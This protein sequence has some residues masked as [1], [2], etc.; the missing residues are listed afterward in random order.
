MKRKKLIVVNTYYQLIFALQLL[1]SIYRNDIVDIIISDQSKD[2]YNISKKVLKLKLFNNVYYEKTKEYTKTN[3]SIFKQLKSAKDVF[4]GTRFYEEV[5]KNR[6]DEFVFFNTDLF[7]YAIFAKLFEGNKDIRGSR[8]EEGIF[9]YNIESYL[10]DSKLRYLNCLRK[11]FRKKT[12]DEIVDKF[13]C[14]YPQIYTGPLKAI[15]VPLISQHCETAKRL[16]NIFKPDISIYNKKYIFFTSVYDFEGGKAI[17]EYELVC[18]IA[19]L[20]GKDNLLIKTHPRD[21]RS[22]YTDNEFNVD[23][24]SSI[25]WEAIQILGDFSDKIFMT[26]NSGSVLSG[27]IMSEKP[28][29]TYYMYRLCNIKENLACIR[30]V[31]N[32]EQLLKEKS[33]KEVLKTVKIAEKIEDIL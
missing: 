12:L 26:I 23:K 20:V 21:V 16:R 3:S 8:F 11:I 15:A 32:I 9:S 31:Q 13:Y 6:Y 27:S 19:D 28:V 29:K 5:W 25:P 17:G 18:K 22:I 24:N 30:N 7:T 1:D 2:A 10:Y 14:F 33:M 4:K